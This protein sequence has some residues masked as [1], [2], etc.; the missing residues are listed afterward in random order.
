MHEKICRRICIAL[1][2]IVLGEGCWL[3]YIYRNGNN[4]KKHLATAQSEL[5]IAAEGNEYLIKEL[6]RSQSRIG[7]LE[8]QQRQS[9]DYQQQLERELKLG[10]EYI[11]RLEIA[12]RDGSASLGRIE[13]YIVEYAELIRLGS[14]FIEN[15]KE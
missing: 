12:E 7:E 11:R 6:R 5:S 13:K 14:E 4:T 2:I 15:G 1:A 10:K 9:A 3:G 8:T